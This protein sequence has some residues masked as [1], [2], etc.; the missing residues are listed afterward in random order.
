MK[1][2]GLEQTK[3]AVRAE[4]D[5]IVEEAQAVVEAAGI[6]GVRLAKSRVGVDHADLRG[7]IRQEHERGD[8]YARS[9]MRAGVGLE[10]PERAAFH[11]WG[12]GP[13]T[14]VPEG[15]EGYARRYYVNGQGQTLP[16][17][18]FFISHEEAAKE[19][20]AALREIAKRR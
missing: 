7:S 20:V 16:N 5:K 11:E 14:V 19:M 3:R 1:L 6:K 17:P 8:G 15:L 18:F 10:K 9:T 4:V 2:K 12:T 13:N